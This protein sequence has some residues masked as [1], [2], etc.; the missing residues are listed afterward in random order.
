MDRLIKM[1][2]I[3]KIIRTGLCSLIIRIAIGLTVHLDMF[4]DRYN[5]LEK[6]LSVYILLSEEP[7]F[8][9]RVSIK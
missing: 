8:V 6:R 7:E 3:K 5:Q 1:M 4:E 9:S 2:L